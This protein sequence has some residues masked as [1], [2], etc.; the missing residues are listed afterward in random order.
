M[1]NSSTDHWLGLRLFQISAKLPTSGSSGLYFRSKIGP[2]TRLK[3]L[4]QF[5]MPAMPQNA[6]F[7]MK[8]PSDSE[9]LVRALHIIDEWYIRN[10]SGWKK[11]LHIEPISIQGALFLIGIFFSNGSES[12][13]GLFF[14][15]RFWMLKVLRKLRNLVL[16]LSTLHTKLFVK[17]RIY[18]QISF[19]K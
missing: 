15:W 18:L 17:H 16:Y 11:N 19:F 1:L 10:Q 12:K 6:S 4:L 5:A 8:N 3:E 9:L 7:W 14:F 13:K 2:S